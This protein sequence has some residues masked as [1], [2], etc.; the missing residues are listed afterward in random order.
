V[1]WWST[2][3][4][5]PMRRGRAH[6]SAGKEGDGGVGVSR[7]G[8]TPSAKRHSLPSWSIARTILFAS[9]CAAC[10]YAASVVRSNHKQPQSLRA[11]PPPSPATPLSTHSVPAG[12]EELR[13]ASATVLLNQSPV[14]P[15]GRKQRLAAIS[16]SW[17]VSLRQIPGYRLRILCRRADDIAAVGLPRDE[18]YE[19]PPEVEEKDAA[20]QLIWALSRAVDEGTSFVMLANDHTFLVPENLQCFLEEP[21]LSAG[22]NNE[23]HMVGHLLKENGVKGA[24][25][26]SGA[27]GVIFSHAL[28]VELL[29]RLASDE[30]CVGSVRERAQPGLLVAKCTRAIGVV[31]RDSVDWTNA[32]RFNV[33]G[34]VRL[35][36]GN[37]DEWWRSYRRNAG[38]DAR[39]GAACCSEELIT[40][41]YAF[42]PEQLLV[43]AALRDKGRFRAMDAETRRAS[44]PS[45]RE[46]GGYS[47]RP[48]SL[49][50]SEEVW[51]LLLDKVSVGCN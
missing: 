30:R 5:Q 7:E 16:Q 49:A 2:K 9:C 6:G 27:A 8:D 42:G 24:L 43:N 3:P 15:A 35:V 32:S 4:T 41:H 13:R 14:D 36:T 33:Y 1:E 44:W 11:I 31:P 23:Y 38:V 29:L 17:A 20:T 47:Y 28:L 21:P 51:S 26:L 18:L 48:P 34:P 45:Q 19:M 39:S 40:F 50:K 46:L 25:F 10:H 12:K 37:T 22:P